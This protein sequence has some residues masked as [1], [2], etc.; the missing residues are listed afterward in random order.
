[1]DEDLKQTLDAMQTQNAQAFAIVH[2]EISELRGEM[3]L[4]RRDNSATHTETRL[5]FD[6]V[7]NRLAA[8]VRHYFDVTTEAARHEIRLIAEAV[9][10]LDEKVERR[11]RALEER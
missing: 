7:A 3:D 6:E 10:H 11:I 1:M 4:M 5:Y 2:R 8:E 9:V